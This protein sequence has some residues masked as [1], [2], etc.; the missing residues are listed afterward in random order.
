VPGSKLHRRV[1]PA[2]VNNGRT[3]PSEAIQACR[4]SDRARTS[5][6]QLLSLSASPTTT[7]SLPPLCATPKI[8]FPLFLSLSATSAPLVRLPLMHFPKLAFNRRRRPTATGSA[9]ASAQPSTPVEPASRSTFYAIKSTSTVSFAASRAKLGNE[10][11][12]EGSSSVDKTAGDGFI[13]KLARR[14]ASKQELWSTRRPPLTQLSFDDSDDDDAGFED[15]RARRSRPY[16]FGQRVLPSPP[17]PVDVE[18]LSS[19]SPFCTDEEERM[20]QR[21]RA[22][23]AR[24]ASSAGLP[25]QLRNDRDAQVETLCCDAA[26][27]GRRTLSVGIVGDSRSLG[28]AFPS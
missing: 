10:H 28:Q 1:S 19:M 3:I 26:E 11:S 4:P 6:R 27:E 5:S 16:A 22:D 14:I 18:L 17:P 12:S 8:L 24:R 25:N 13:R 20:R 7:L 15:D 23:R 9:Q 21:Y 2:T